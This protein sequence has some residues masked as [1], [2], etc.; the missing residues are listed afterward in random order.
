MAYDGSRFGVFQDDGKG[1]MWR[2]SF[3]DLAE[4][5]REAK[6]LSEREKVDYFVYCFQSFVE[7]ARFRPS[8]SAPAPKLTRLPKPQPTTD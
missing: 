5:K 1:P 7:I 2:A 8:R 6:E 4:A 3:A